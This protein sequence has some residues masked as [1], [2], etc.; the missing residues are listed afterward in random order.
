MIKYNRFISVLIS[1]FFFLLYVSCNN[2]DIGQQLVCKSS[3]CIIQNKNHKKTDALS[4]YQLEKAELPIGLK[5][6]YADEELTKIE[7]I[8]LIN[9]RFVTSIAFDSLGR[10]SFLSS[11]IPHGKAL[12]PKTD[13]GYRINLKF[14][15]IG[16]AIEEPYTPWDNRLL[17]NK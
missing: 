6:Y 4:Q 8:R 7:Y 12:D 17:K 9:N 15:S 13:S 11:Y 1:L 14:D 2:N 3:V 16:N 5:I 10:V